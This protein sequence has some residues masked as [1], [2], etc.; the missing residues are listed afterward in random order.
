LP[1]FVSELST[2]PIISAVPDPLVS[3]LPLPCTTGGL[4]VPDGP[5]RTGSRIG[6]P[7]ADWPSVGDATAS[8]SNKTVGG[9]GFF[10]GFDFA[11][12]FAF[13]FPPLNC[14]DDEEGKDSPGIEI[15]GGFGV[16]IEIL[17]GFGVG[18]EILGGFV[19]S[20]ILGGVNCRAAEGGR[21]TD[22]FCG[23]ETDGGREVEGGLFGVEKEGCFDDQEFE[24]F[25][26]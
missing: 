21:E 4:I 16:G 13:W 3:G 5:G 1:L 15:L 26:V 6:T 2:V 10:G 18:I 17:G 19:G 20:E 23:R 12:L 25:F 24:D 11:V 22:G 8:V 7:S 9:V 14:V